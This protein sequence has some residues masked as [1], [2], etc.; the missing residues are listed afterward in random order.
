M[1]QVVIV[2]IKH[3]YMKMYW[4]SL[5]TAPHTQ[6]RTFAGWTLEGVD[7]QLQAMADSH[8]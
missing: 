7:G 3:Y 6:T 5:D 4:G 2:L 1:Q 8:P